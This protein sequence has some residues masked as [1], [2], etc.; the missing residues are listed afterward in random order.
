MMKKIAIFLSV[1]VLLIFSSCSDENSNKNESKNAK[2]PGYERDVTY[3][4]MSFYE[5]LEVYALELIDEEYDDSSATYK[6]TVED[7]WQKADAIKDKEVILNE[8][9]K[10]YTYTIVLDGI[11][12]GEPVRI[13]VRF[14]CK[15]IEATNTI[16]VMEL[17]GDEGTPEFIS[18]SLEIDNIIEH[19]FP[20]VIHCDL[21]DN[22]VES[23][24]N[25]CY[26]HKCREEGCPNERL[27]Y[28]VYCDLHR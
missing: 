1:A 2:L 19:I 24:S 23:N 10:A 16:E 22:A 27:S 11:S 8:D 26:R 12:Y 28:S 25:Y 18:D 14:F 13:T 6:I 7:G 15:L 21:C 9:E 5:M 3:G 17:Y 20:K 4:N